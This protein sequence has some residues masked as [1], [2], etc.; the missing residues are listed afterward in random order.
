LN[1]TAGSTVDDHL[2][3]P[4]RDFRVDLFRGLALWLIFIDHS[5]E[6][7]LS[8]FTLKNLG[9]SDAAEIFVF[10]SGLASGRVY[11]AVARE[12]G[13]VAAS[14]RALRRGFQIYLAE[15]TLFW[16]Y[17]AEVSFLAQWR[18]MFLHDANIA[19]FL[20]H[21]LKGF[22]EVMSL[23]YSPVNIDVLIL[24]V[25]L[26]LALP[27]ILPAVMWRPRAAL[28][29]SALIYAATHL[30]RWAIPA[31]P[32]G[33]LYFNP[34]AW[35]FLYVIGVWWGATQPRLPPGPNRSALTMLAATFLALSLA[36]A[37]TWQI[38]GVDLIAATF[39]Y[40]LYPIDKGNFALIRLVHFLA[41]AFVCYR[42]VPGNNTI[43][44]SRAAR[45]LVQCGEHSLVI[46]CLGV[47]LAF[48]AHAVLTLVSNTLSAQIIVTVAGII[49][50]SVVAALLSRLDR[51]LQSHP[52]TI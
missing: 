4:D 27:A 28:V 46:Y 12:R 29:V 10:L 6:N 49:A 36:I 39:G 14:R 32:V 47:L 43:L 45:P 20:A 25:I 30:F 38:R 33:T 48:A 16:L 34:L 7:T 17:V 41:L 26:H 52:R 3:A 51:S 31:Y 15:M 24:M 8:H 50:M 2:I 18:S 23:R 21:P 13:F 5:P 35:Q 19:I 1:D 22:L 42:I 37:L 9:F 11:G 44:R 40:S